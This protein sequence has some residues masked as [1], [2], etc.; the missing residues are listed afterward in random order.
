ME[1]A[2][3]PSNGLTFKRLDRAIDITFWKAMRIAA[4]RNRSNSPFPPALIVFRS[5]W[6]PTEVKKKTM[7]TSRIVL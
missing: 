3:K 6:K 4:E 1:P 7:Q 2:H 5:I